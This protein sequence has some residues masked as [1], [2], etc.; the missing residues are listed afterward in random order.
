NLFSAPVQITI[1]DP[2]TGGTFQLFV[3]GPGTAAPNVG[4]S[5]LPANANASTIQ[6][7]LNAAYNTF[8]GTTGVTYVTVVLSSSTPTQNVFTVNSISPLLGAAQPVLGF[9]F[10]NPTDPNFKVTPS[11][12]TLASQLGLFNSIG[13]LP[14]PSAPGGITKL[15]SQ[16]LDIQADGNYSG[17]VDIQAGV[18]LVQ[19]SSALGTPGT[20]TGP[21]PP[22][23]TTT[24]RAAAAPVL[25]N[26]DGHNQS[27]IH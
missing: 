25:A 15:G 8:F 10:I 19:N 7:A 1:D 4:T 5:V 9:L 13:E 14:A 23:N 24:V 12:G 26:P 21:I 27:R 17:A 20:Y 16:L 6:T 18:L 3:P 2:N 22:S 11:G